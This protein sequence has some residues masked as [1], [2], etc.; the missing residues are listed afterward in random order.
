MDKTSFEILVNEPPTGYSEFARTVLLLND[1]GFI[2]LTDYKEILNEKKAL[3]ESMIEHD[4]KHLEQWFT[5]FD[6][7]VRIWSEFVIKSR[8]LHFV[9]V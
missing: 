2:E 6:E 8:V 1:E 4:A 5:P 3:F 9:R 7:S